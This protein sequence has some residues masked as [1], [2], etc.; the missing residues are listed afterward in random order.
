MPRGKTVASN[1]ESIL[2]VVGPG[3]T[4]AFPYS[5]SMGPGL[6]PEN[7]AFDTDSGGTLYFYG[8]AVMRGSN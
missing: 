7:F 8:Y 1:P 4:L 6:L 5:G 2:A 3:G